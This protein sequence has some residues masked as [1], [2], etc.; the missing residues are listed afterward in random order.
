MISDVQHVYGIHINLNATH[1]PPLK[2]LRFN[3]HSIKMVDGVTRVTIVH[4]HLELKV[5]H[6]VY[7]LLIIVLKTH[8]C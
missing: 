3:S 6:F 4:V 5:A 8:V 1:K 7:F 2:K